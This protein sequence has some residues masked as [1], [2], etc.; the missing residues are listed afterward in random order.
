MSTFTPASG[1]RLWITYQLLNGIARGVMAQQPVTT[2]QANLPPEHI[3][4]G[5][6]L[7]LFSQNFGASVFISLGQT[8]FENTLHHGLD[9]AAR[10]SDINVQAVSGAGATEFRELVRADAVGNVVE[11]YM[12]RWCRPSISQPGRRWPCSC[13]R[14]GSGSRV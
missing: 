2:M 14:G 12:G 7:A 3:S 10:T 5:T 1:P 9:D 4:I 8:T 6:A 11:A 13:W